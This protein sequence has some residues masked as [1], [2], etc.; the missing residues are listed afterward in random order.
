MVR[1]RCKI[2]TEQNYA[3]AEDLLNRVITHDLDLDVTVQQEDY[4]EKF[5]DEYDINYRKT[6]DSGATLK[7]LVNTTKANKDI[8]GGMNV[9]ENEE[10]EAILKA[11]KHNISLS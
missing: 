6:A 8:K 11:G 5:F 1:F 2:F 4:L 9:L 7:S 10:V 3:A